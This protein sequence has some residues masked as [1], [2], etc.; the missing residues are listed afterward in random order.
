MYREAF[1]DNELYNCWV[2][3]CT[4]KEISKHNAVYYFFDKENI[5]WDLPIFISCPKSISL[6]CLHLPKLGNLLHW[7]VS[8]DFEIW[9]N[10]TTGFAKLQWRHLCTECFLW[11]H[12]KCVYVQSLVGVAN[13]LHELQCSKDMYVYTVQSRFSDTFGL[14]KNCH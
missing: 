6:F 14:C 9:Y 10:T 1:A 5:N 13:C 3:Y 8:R 7:Q 12:W 2:S 4:F 11:L